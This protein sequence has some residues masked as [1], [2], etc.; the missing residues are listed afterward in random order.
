MANVLGELFSDIA[1][2]IRGKTGETGSMKPI[3]FPDKIAAIEAG[4]GEDDTEAV[5]LQLDEIN[6]EVIGQELYTYTFIGA[7]GEQLGTMTVY[8]SF[9]CEDPVSA[10]AFATPTKASTRYLE[11]TFTGWSKTAGGV[12]DKNALKS[13]FSDLTLYASFRESYIYLASGYFGDLKWGVDPDYLLRIT[14]NGALPDVGG[15]SDYTVTPWAAYTS[16]LTAVTIGSGV[17]EIG[18]RNFQDCSA[19]TKAT[20]PD[21]LTN[22]AMQAFMGC[23]AL[24]EI[25][26]PEGVKYLETSAFY[27]CAALTEITIPSTLRAVFPTVFYSSGLTRAVFANTVGWRINDSDAADF[28]DYR[29]VTAEEMADPA[30]LATMLRETYSEYNWLTRDYTT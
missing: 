19:V 10:G 17:T 18:D 24:A 6:G 13:A 4:S 26:I 2:A 5:N 3:E 11:Y 23:T 1:A 7:D 22:I 15:Y 27:G 8:E 14:G 25:N 9:N 12:A 28:E 16:Q 30:T 20:L 29:E 21:T